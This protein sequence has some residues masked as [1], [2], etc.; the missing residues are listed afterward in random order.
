MYVI[1]LSFFKFP[2]VGCEP[3]ASWVRENC[4]TPNDYNVEYF[5]HI[6][7]NPEELNMIWLQK[8]NSHS[9]TRYSS[10]DQDPFLSVAY[11][12]I[13]H[14]LDM[15][16]SCH[17]ILSKAI[18]SEHLTEN[19]KVKLSKTRLISLKS[20]QSVVFPHMCTLFKP[21]SLED[22]WRWCVHNDTSA[23]QG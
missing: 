2:S 13:F 3:R 12:Q 19:G 21:Q 11:G 23:T 16:G 5:I 7:Y 1:P 9:E 15:S 8:Q 17:D 10:F 6:G 14:H 18:L 4:R 22:C 20:R